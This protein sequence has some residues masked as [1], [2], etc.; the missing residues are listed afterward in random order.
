MGLIEDI[1][2]EFIDPVSGEVNL[3]SFFQPLL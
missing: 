1:R 2:K 3:D